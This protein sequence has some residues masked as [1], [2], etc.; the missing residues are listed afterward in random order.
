M[1]TILGDPIEGKGDISNPFSR[2]QKMLFTEA[3]PTIRK[4][5]RQF[6]QETKRCKRFLFRAFNPDEPEYGFETRTP[7]KDRVPTDTPKKVQMAFDNVYEDT[8]GWRPRQT[9]VF[10][11]N[12]VEG[13][14]GYGWTHY[15]FPIGKYRYAWSPDV[16]DFFIVQGRLGLSKSMPDKNLLQE[17]ERLVKNYKDSKDLCKI[18]SS[19]ISYEVILGCKKYYGVLWKGVEQETLGP[20]F[21]RALWR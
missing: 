6:L 4:D 12:S 11:A 18:L 14:Y 16:R 13:T 9:G 5:C 21:E 8:Y 15:I 10:C 20:D 19:N 7:R 17:M 1:T 2:F 3:V